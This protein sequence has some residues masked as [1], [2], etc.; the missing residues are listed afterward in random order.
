[1]CKTQIKDPTFSCGHKVRRRWEQDSHPVP[2]T[3]KS[4]LLSR[5]WGSRHSWVQ[6]SIL[7]PKCSAADEDSCGAPSIPSSIRA[8]AIGQSLGYWQGT[9]LTLEMIYNPCG[10]RGQRGCGHGRRDKLCQPNSGLEIFD[11]CL[12]LAV[13]RPLKPSFG[14][15]AGWDIPIPHWGGNCYF[16]A[17]INFFI[18]L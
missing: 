16:I 17:P 6:V 11:L 14:D 5:E 9:P 4:P 2:E 7:T 18:C 8:R 13:T 1:M 10:V 3:P 12:P 15:S